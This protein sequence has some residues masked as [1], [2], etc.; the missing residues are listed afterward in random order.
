MTLKVAIA[1]SAEDRAACLELRRR[2]FIIEQGV[3]EAEEMDGKDEACLHV[4]ARLEGAPVGAA[5]FNYVGEAVKIQRVCVPIEARGRGVGEAVMRFMLDYA[6]AEGVAALARL[7][8]Q[9]QALAFYRKLGFEAY[10]EEYLDA[11]IPHFDMQ[12]ALD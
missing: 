5:R 8:S 4:L 1:A 2:V 12:R 6:Q 9:T 11:G 7:S 10:G 3:D